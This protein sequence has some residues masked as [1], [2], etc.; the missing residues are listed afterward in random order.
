MNCSF[1]KKKRKKNQ[2]LF[3]SRNCTRV[4]LALFNNTR[5]MNNNEL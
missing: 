1:Y 3:Y 4:S 5:L 2:F